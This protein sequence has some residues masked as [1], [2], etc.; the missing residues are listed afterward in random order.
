MDLLYYNELDYSRVKKQFKKVEKFLAED[1]F[2]SAQIKK[3]VNTDYFRAKLDD[4]NRLLFKFGKYQGRFYILI[5]EVIL[6]H[7]YEKSKFLRGVHIDESKLEVIESIQKTPA[8]DVSNLLYINPRHAHF[9]VLD[10][11]ISFDDIQNEIYSLPAPLII[12][13]SAGSGKTALTLEKLKRL[14]GN[15]A[16][17]SLSAYLVENARQTY[18]AHNYENGKQEIDFLTFSDYLKSIKIPK[19]RELTYKVFEEWFGKH[20]HNSKID[21]PFRLFEEFKGVLTGS[22]TDAASLSEENYLNLGVKQSIFTSNQRKEVFQIFKKFLR[23]LIESPFYDINMLSYEYLQFVEPKYDFVVIDEVQDITN[24]Q[25]SVILKS[26]KNRH[27]FMLSGDS[28]QIVHPNFFSW[29][30]IKTLFFKSN[31]DFTLTRILKTN[32]R[33]SQKVTEISNTL[34]KIKNLRFG[35]VD[36]ESTYLINSVSEKDGEVY[37]MNDDKKANRDLNSKTQSSARFAVLVMNN[38]DKIQVRKFFKTPLVFSVQEAKGLEYENIIL[39]NF[40]S[41][42]SKEFFELTKGVEP[43]SL[44]DEMKYGRAGNKEDKDLEVYK[45]YVN[46]LYVAFTRSVR[47]LYILEQNRNHRLFE[48]LELRETKQKVQLEAQKSNEKEWL[49]EADKLELQ[50]KHEQAQQIR[51]R[52]SGVQYISSEEYLDLQ[53][54]ALDPNKTEQEV[55]RERKTLFR[56]A[57]ARK[58]IDI[59]E[60]LAELQFNRA[61]LYMRQIRALRKEFEKACRLNRM[62]EVKKITDKYGTDF[63]VNDEGVSG[64]MYA[65]SL[66]NIETATYFLNN[67]ADINLTDQFGYNPLRTALLAMIKSTI[68][69]PKKTKEYTVFLECVYARLKVPQ[70]RCIINDRL[71]IVND[72]SMQYFLVNF[73]LAAQ[74]AIIKEKMKEMFKR[75]D[76]MLM[77]LPNDQQRNIKRRGNIDAVDTGLSMN[78]FLTY[79]DQMPEF[80]L[81][82]YRRKRSYIN[83]ILSNNEVDRDFIYNQKLFKRVERGVYKLNPELKI[84]VTDKSDI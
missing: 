35:S 83:S 40:V 65:V 9:H 30:K 19:G 77:F 1:N 5:L 36:K 46:S 73:L 82:D 12:I 45:F 51:D 44:K 74:E 38:T 61:I 27:N 62:I 32:Y 20:I 84:E 70:L 66:G 52:L 37:L 34:L 75:L 64:L 63:P 68:S 48:L 60:Q 31:F 50:G 39:F 6:N 7:E 26:L 79:I 23:F 25:L 11:I 43:E 57:E 29:S 8:D 14:D 67:K 33:N 81:V 47:N 56:Y 24:V 59:I 41:N 2:K 13:G 42:N 18:Y 53:R 16:Y 55:K 21:E 49:E 54:T 15:V 3:V 10:K 76:S 17:I 58:H 4:T 80:V 22:V 69:I 28:N 72:R 71:V 78:D